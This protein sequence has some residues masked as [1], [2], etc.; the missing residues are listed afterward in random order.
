[1]ATPPIT[2]RT[3]GI[4][5]LA[6]G[7]AATGLARAA[8][9]EEVPPA[10]PGT[11]A[12]IHV[13]ITQE[14]GDRP[15]LTVK[16]LLEWMDAEGIAQAAVLPIDSPESWFFP[17]TTDYVLKETKDHRDR[18]IP[19]CHVDPRTL[20]L[21]SYDAKRDLLL[22]YR[23]AGA[24]GFG[25]HKVGMPIDDPRNLQIFRACAEAGL[26]VLFHLDNMR[27]SDAPGLPGLEK[28]L[29]E[30]PDGV[31]IGHAQGWWASISGDVTQEE[32]Q[33]YPNKP[34]APGG[35]IDRLMDA[36]PN[37]YGDLSAGSGANAIL[38][39]MD[40]GRAFLERRADRLLFGTDYLAPKQ[41]V[42]Q[43]SLYNDI[44]LPEAA[45]AKIF[46]DNARRILGV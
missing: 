38:R 33:K 3:F 17:I 44:D 12:D 22:R 43:F 18:L 9:A 8:R 29:Q 1:M 25:E 6:A 46:R 20:N 34:V 27:N 7:L 13:H 37:L 26:P 15:A 19:F 42:P 36:Y 2:R 35:A 24:R 14:W 16:G 11:Y 30:N 39:D 32:L 21:G 28:V 10:P 41:K 45:K 5:T 23:D 4:Q 40:F 31:F